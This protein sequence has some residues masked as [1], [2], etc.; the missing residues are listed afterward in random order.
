MIMCVCL[1]VPPLSCTTPILQD[2]GRKDFP[3]LS[4]VPYRDNLL[5]MEYKG[6]G[7]PIAGHVG[8]EGEQSYS[9]TLPLTSSLDRGE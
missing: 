9:S 2:G 7:Q 6:K 3:L 1:S 8:P 5:I 4:A